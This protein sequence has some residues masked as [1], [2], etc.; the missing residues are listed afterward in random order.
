VSLNDVNG[1][2]LGA[3]TVSGNLTITANGLITDSGNV[4]VAGATSLAAGVANGITLSHADNFVGPVSI[5]SGKDV[6]LNDVNGLTLGAST[7]SGNLT[8]TA[9]GLISDSGNVSVAGATSLAAGSANNITLSQAD[10]FVGPVS[11]VSG[12][13]VSLN[14]VNGL[15]LGAST[16]SGNLT[17][18]ANGLITD[19]G[20]VSVAGA[21]SLAAGVANG[22]TLSHADNF[23]GPVSIV[24]G[25]D[26][27]LNDVNGLTLG[28][29]TVS[30]NL[31]VTANGLISDSGNVSVAGATSLAAGSPNNI[32]LTHADAFV[33]PLS[34]ASGNNVTLN[35]SVALTFG[36]SSISGN[37][38]VT[39]AGA[40]SQIGPL[41]VNGAGKTANFSAAGNNITLLNANNDFA[42]VRFTG[43]DVAVNDLN[44]LDLGVSTIAGNLSVTAGGPITQSGA[45]LANGVGKTA[46]FIAPGSSITLTDP[47]ND[48]TTA[49]FTGSDV[50]VNDVNALD[51][52]ASTLSGNL[53]VTAG[54][55]I[56]QSGALTVNGAGKIANFSA[57]GNSITL[58]ANNDFSTAEFTGADVAI[59][60]INALDLGASKVTGNLL[61]TANGTISQS[62]V[63]TANGS[64]KLATFA[65][66]AA[67]DVILGLNNEFA[68]VSVPAANNITLKAANSFALSAVNAA[69]TLSLNTT[70]GDITQ[71][72]DGSAIKAGTLSGAV[73]GSLILGNPANASATPGVQFVAA[74]Q[75]QNQFGSISSLSHNG[76]L[77]IF[78]S[79]TAHYGDLTHPGEI[80][81]PLPAQDPT[82]LLGLKITGPVSGQGFTVIRTEGDLVLLGSGR[83]TTTAG[84]IELS[85]E[86]TATASANFDNLAGTIAANGTPLPNAASGAIAVQAGL[87]FINHKPGA[88]ASRFLIFSTDAKQNFGE[89][90]AGDRLTFNGLGA[91]FIADQIT[92]GDHRSPILKQNAQPDDGFGNGFVFVQKQAILQTDETAKFFFDLLTV[93]IVNAVD[94]TAEVDK[95][96]PERPPTI[97]TSS[98]HVY[99]EERKKKKKRTAQLQGPVFAANVAGE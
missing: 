57:P 49:K 51:L 20:N 50:A 98:Y 27:S 39:A 54:G 5:V 16:V 94:A 13:D 87:D 97:W 18:T 59:N 9:N 45:L 48:F 96:P 60:D 84:D 25:K 24:S 80:A 6:S 88:V 22:I 79:R 23:V 69:G 42:T 83:V 2:T 37:L 81:N 28:A 66:G 41:T 35:D 19:S 70:A 15:T 12:K 64:G 10:S 3:S 29:S 82:A 52:G 11:I 43:A 86:S 63:I 31:A 34:I 99:L 75:P 73:N 76:E 91:D 40:I 61:V 1:L 47:N 14:D 30:G 44:G 90:F 93:A 74:P 46:T 77:Y 53:T 56:T 4:S 21:T 8:V 68:T 72:L 92:F 71:V 32:S 26:V 58:V 33:G 62:G 95:L 17:V 65:P 38:N 36:A 7:V 78:N 55:P 67:N 89:S 85:A